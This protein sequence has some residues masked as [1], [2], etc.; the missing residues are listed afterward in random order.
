MAAVYRLGAQRHAGYDGGPAGH[1][2]REALA[3]KHPAEPLCLLSD[4]TTVHDCRCQLLVLRKRHPSPSRI[5]MRRLLSRDGQSELGN[6]ISM[7][8]FCTN[9][10]FT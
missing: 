7:F 3:R 9:V 10:C 8:L 4:T 6:A 1:G 5:R 2:G